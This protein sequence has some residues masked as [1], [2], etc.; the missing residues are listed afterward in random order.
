MIIEPKPLASESCHYYDRT[1]NPVYEVPNAS[2]GGMRPTTVRDAKKL[3]LLPSV[4]TVMGV[5]AKPAINGWVKEQV[6]RAA[7][8]VFWGEGETADEWVAHVLKAAETN[9]TQARD[10]GTEIHGAIERYLKESKVKKEHPNSILVPGMWVGD[11]GD[12]V[13][14]YHEHIRAA[15]NA[16]IELGVWGQPFSPEKSFASALGYGGKVDL[17]GTPEN[18][19]VV[20]FKCVDRLD[21][22]LDYPDRCQQLTA[23]ADGLYCDPIGPRQAN[24]FISTS[25]PGKYL[26]REWK[27]DEKAKGNR[28]F[29]AALNLWCE[30]YNFYP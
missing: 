25:E 24:I 14:T 29:R 1:G 2:K 7:V 20:D 10:L 4:S 21:K 17:S 5:V 16:L 15:V 3:D 18:P 6:A 28:V 23:Y 27:E 11:F 26:I 30:I 12:F 8:N 19:W 13:T 22:K 9:M